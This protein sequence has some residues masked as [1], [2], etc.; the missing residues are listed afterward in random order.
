MAQKYEN[1]P[2]APSY[3]TDP[4]YGS[5]PTNQPTVRPSHAHRVSLPVIP[6]SNYSSLSS[7]RSPG[8]PNSRAP[9][10]DERLNRSAENTTQLREDRQSRSRHPSICGCEDCS[11]TGY[12]SPA[13]QHQQQRV[14]SENLLSGSGQDTIKSTRSDRRVSMPMPAGNGRY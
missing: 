1:R 6:S 3:P 9:V 8:L 14:F 5:P 11:A 10:P 7:S 2:S 4:V 12:T 13:L